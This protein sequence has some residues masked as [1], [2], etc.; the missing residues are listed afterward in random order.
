VYVVDELRVYFSPYGDVVDCQIMLD[1]NT[2]RS[3]G[4]GFVTFDNEDS[5]EKVF[6]AGKIHEIGGKQVSETIEVTIG[7]SYCAAHNLI[8]FFSFGYPFLTINIG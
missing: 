8:L 1:H 4:F 6:S 5:V 2:G 7:Y 3:R